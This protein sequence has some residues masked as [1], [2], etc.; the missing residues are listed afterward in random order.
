MIFPFCWMD[1]KAI[2]KYQASL[3]TLHFNKIEKKWI[4]ALM[5]YPFISYLIIIIYSEN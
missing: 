1:I 4:Y 5:D 2:K 3:N